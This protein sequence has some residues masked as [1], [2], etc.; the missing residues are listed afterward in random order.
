MEGFSKCLSIG[1]TPAFTKS[2]RAP[3]GTGYRYSFTGKMVNE[4]QKHGNLCQTKS[5]PRYG[6]QR[7]TGKLFRL[8]IH[9]GL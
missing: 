3:K 7:L 9:P 5:L 4:T 1:L 8:A 6:V 2:G